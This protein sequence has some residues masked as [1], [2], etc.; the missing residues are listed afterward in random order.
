[1]S[2]P[3]EFENILDECLERL[4]L[5]DETIEQ[6]LQSFP[7]YAD[8][9]K[10]LLETALTASEATDIQPRSEFRDRAR[11]EF[12]SVLEEAGQK[13][14]RTLFGWGWQPRW[15]T[16]VA[17][18]LVLVLGSG[19]TAIAANNTM[20]NDF[21]YPVKLASEQ[22]QLAFTFTETGKA[23]VHA[24]LADKRVMEIVYL[25]DTDDTDKIASV[26]VNLNGHLTEIA[27]LSSPQGEATM[28]AVAPAT[29]DAEAIEEE[30][31][32]VAEETRVTAEAEIAAGAPAE[33][34]QVTMEA[35][36]L[37]EATVT[38]KAPSTTGRAG[39]NRGQNKK[40]DQNAQ[41]W[42]SVGNQANTNSLKLQA[43]LDKVPESARSGILRAINLSETVYQNSLQIDE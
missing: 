39:D 16:A 37:D 12:Y 1:M 20:P 10:P 19:G 9:L 6:C 26:T 15:V 29:E 35:F 17:I 23:E 42:A 3:R 2:K 32:E 14:S 21:L 28:L 8:E 43:L 24:R 25:V 13:K 11:Y 18:A 36:G 22:V 31:M 4:L 40:D 27:G 34:E 5:R 41:V 38:E 30:E 33:E 7:D